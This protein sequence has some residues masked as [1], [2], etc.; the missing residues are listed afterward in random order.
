MI[1]RIL[2]N[3]PTKILG[4]PL[5]KNRPL[6]QGASHRQAPKFPYLL[7]HN[8]LVT[9]ISIIFWHLLH[10]SSKNIWRLSKIFL[11]LHRNQVEC[12]QRDSKMIL[13]ILFI[14]YFEDRSLSCTFRAA[15]FRFPQCALTWLFVINEHMRHNR[16]I[17]ISSENIARASK[18]EDFLLVLGACLIIKSTFVNSTI[19]DFSYTSNPQPY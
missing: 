13:D 14:I 9:S 10:F 15:V 7:S 11:S 6:G 4:S 17:E 3:I 5:Y 16:T 8:H 12:T 1:W 18:D 2:K 19:S